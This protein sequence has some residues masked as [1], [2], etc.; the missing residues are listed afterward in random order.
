[1][2]KL[3]AFLLVAATLLCLFA[4]DEG[5]QSQTT[6]HHTGSTTISGSEGQQGNSGSTTTHNHSDHLTTDIGGSGGEGTT[7]ADGELTTEGDEG[8]YDEEESGDTSS[9][10]STTVQGVQATTGGGQVITTTTKKGET[11]K[12]TTTTT[13]T[14]KKGTTSTT[15]KTTT[16]RRTVSTGID[17]STVRKHT[18]ATATYTRV[19]ENLHKAV[20][21]CTVCGIS[22]S[23]TEPHTWGSW[24]Y[25]TYPTATKQGVKYRTCSGCKEEQ[26]TY[27]PPTSVNTA[28]FPQ[29]MFELINAERTKRGLTPFTYYTSAQNGANVRAQEL[30]VYFSH[31][32]P[33][34]TKWWTAAGFDK[35]VCQAGAENIA[36][37]YGSPEDVMA[38]FMASSS[39]TANILSTKY[40]HVVIGYYEGAWVQIF[41]KPW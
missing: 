36:R 1:M 21:K 34:G 41:T 31:N 4:C 5:G 23:Q 14:T 13:T 20:G 24:A 17:S 37:G 38:A 3:M 33:D 29:Q 15:K 39:H 19:D 35:S 2:K 26:V 8:G 22:G 16:T 7:S 18:Y 27:V 25:D 11:T 12:K 40:T 6:T 28:N 32:R 10:S 9:T 30:M